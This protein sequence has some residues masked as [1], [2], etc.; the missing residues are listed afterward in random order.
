MKK[1]ILQQT[2]KQVQTC[3]NEK[4]SKEKRNFNSDI[5]KLLEATTGYTQLDVLVNPTAVLKIND[6]EHFQKAVNLYLKG[7]PLYRILGAREFFGIKFL[8]NEETLEPRDDT[9]VLV[10]TGLNFLQ[11]EHPVAESKIL[12]IGTGTGIIAISLLS[13]LPQA[14]ALATDISAKALEIAQKN[15]K[16]AALEKRI[17]FIKSDG[18]EKIQGTFDLI[19][20]NPPY[21]PTDV[22]E[23]LE[24]NVKTYDPKPALDGGRDGLD[25]YRL[26]AKNCK[27]HMHKKSLLA[28]EIG[29]GQENEIQTIF[30]ES[31]YIL[32]DVIKDLQGINRVLTF[33]INEEYL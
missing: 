10:Q 21:I 11:N 19:I 15:A 8:L 27:K 17:S 3:F 6:Y 22:I 2:V 24:E 5:F 29:K 28:L 13:C 26:F 1:P 18:F 31:D 14:K 9:E 32:K 7:M 23:N 12:D 20:S 25:F 33:Q 4:L 16:N 30:E